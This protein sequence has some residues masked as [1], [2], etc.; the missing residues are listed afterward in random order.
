[1]LQLVQ[2]S[3]ARPWV[4]LMLCRLAAGQSENHVLANYPGMLCRAAADYTKVSPF[5]FL[6]VI[7]SPW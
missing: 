3:T 5:G 7:V 4:E 1:M 6:A 2:A